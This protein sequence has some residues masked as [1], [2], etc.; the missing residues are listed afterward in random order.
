MVGLSAKVLPLLVV[1]AAAMASTGSAADSVAF[2]DCGHGN[3]RRVKILGCKKQP[4]HVKI[5][6]RVT[7]EASFIA[8]FTTSSAVN[9]IGAY[10]ERHRFQLPEPHVDACASGHISPSCPMRKGQVYSYRYTLPV[11]EIY[12]ATPATIEYK[13]VTQ[14]GKVIGCSQVPVVIFR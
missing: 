12:P 1:V 3:V 8:P 2:K 9:D 11:R 7:F 10:I 4:C 14:E 13:L 6:S 5:G